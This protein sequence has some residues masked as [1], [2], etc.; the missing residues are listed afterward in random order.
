METNNNREF[1]DQVIQEAN[2]TN[3]VP[4]NDMERAEEYNKKI[5][6]G[7]IPLISCTGVRFLVDPLDPGNNHLFGPENRMQVITS[8]L[9]QEESLNN[10]CSNLM[11]KGSDRISAEEFDDYVEKEIENLKKSLM[12]FGV[13]VTIYKDANPNL[14]TYDLAMFMVYDLMSFTKTLNHYLTIMMMGSEWLGGAPGETSSFMPEDVFEPGEVEIPTEEPKSGKY[15]N[16]KCY[17]VLG[18]IQPN[19]SV[20]IIDIAEGDTS[21]DNMLIVHSEEDADFDGV[22]SVYTIAP[23]EK[24]ATHDAR[25]VFE[26]YVRDMLETDADKAYRVAE[27]MSASSG[28]LG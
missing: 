3:E 11:L 22:V 7:C 10:I 21:P 12:G 15:E 4:N 18:H 23:D 5:E 16:N 28:L 20:A 13:D 1:M 17:K 14:T 8:F 25:V 19:N 2:A 26:G 27:E 6:E 24:T 9:K